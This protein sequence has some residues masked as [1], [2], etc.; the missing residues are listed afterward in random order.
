LNSIRLKSAG[1]ID[2]V[3]IVVDTSVWIDAHRRPAGTI[4]T[5]LKDLLDADEVALPLPVRLELIAGV[6]RRDRPALTRGLSA[7]PLLRPSA[8]TWTLIEGWIP[9]AA[10]KGHR[11][12]LSDWVIA[13]LAREIDALVWSLDDDFGKLERLKMARRYR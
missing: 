6:S 12:G 7:L 2:G 1:K 8:Q 11:I 13:A 4:A 3:M 10:D 5:T 9:A